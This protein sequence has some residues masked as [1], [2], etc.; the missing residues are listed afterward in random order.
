MHARRLRKRQED[1]KAHE[2]TL[3]DR[4]AKLAQVTVDQAI[5]RDRLGKLKLEVDEG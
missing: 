5:E 1:L 3:V 2:A 4:D